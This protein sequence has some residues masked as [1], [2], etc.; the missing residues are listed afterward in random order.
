MTLFTFMHSNNAVLSSTEGNERRYDE[1]I[2][3]K[4]FILAIFVHYTS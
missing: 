1:M 3:P 2:N 4:K